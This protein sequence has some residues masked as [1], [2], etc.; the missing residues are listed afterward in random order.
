MPNLDG[1]VGALKRS[2][3][4]PADVKQGD[5]SSAP[6]AQPNAPRATPQEQLQNAQATIQAAQEATAGAGA[7]EQ[8]AGDANKDA[9][10]AAKEAQI[11]ELTSALQS[12]TEKIGDLI[13]KWQVKDAPEPPKEPELPALPENFAELPA[14]EQ[15]SALVDTFKSV[16]EDMGKRLI[17][18]DNDLKA[19]LGPLVKEVRETAAEKDKRQILEQYP[20]FEYQKYAPEID[21]L[22]RQ[23]F[24]LSALEAAQLI[25]LKHDANMLTKP[26]A[27]APVVEA[28]RPSMR[29]AA[30]T[31]GGRNRAAEPE[32]N[33]AA[34]RSLQAGILKAQQSGGSVEAN[35]LIE[36]LLRI[37][38]PAAIQNL[39]R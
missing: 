8:D 18:R 39:M 20:K 5:A 30:D 36:Q 27:Q 7:Q 10:L 28:S 32:D 9:A 22:R 1:V 16:R 24:G 26:S 13:S 11:A 23:V 17:A 33:S 4:L 6:H 29:A 14:A 34:I 2:M 19:L 12:Q 35:K 3:G 21:T 37:K 31:S 25:A 15:L 38:A